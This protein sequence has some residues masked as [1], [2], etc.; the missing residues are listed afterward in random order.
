[1][2]VL[3]QPLVEDA[4]VRPV[5]VEDDELVAF[6]EKILNEKGSTLSFKLAT[7][8]STSKAFESP[9]SDN[10]QVQYSVPFGFPAPAL[11]VLEK[12]GKTRE[13]GSYPDT[14]FTGCKGRIY[15]LSFHI[16]SPGSTPSAAAS[17]RTVEGFAVRWRFSIM[18]IVLCET[19]LRSANSRTVNGK[20]SRSRRRAAASI[21]TRPRRRLDVVASKW[22]ILSRRR[23]TIHQFP[24]KRV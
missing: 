10:I 19:S 9:I 21:F 12:T 5:L 3:Q 7:P 22:M 8:W 20:P 14:R 11:C 13:D 17:F 15:L 16:S 23:V 1:L 4:L 24:H 2:R 6:L 18:V